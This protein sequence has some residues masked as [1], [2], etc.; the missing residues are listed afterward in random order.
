MNNETNL[1]DLLDE[2]LESP[3]LDEIERDGAVLKTAER[4]CTDFNYCVTLYL[5]KQKKYVIVYK[6]DNYNNRECIMFREYCPE[7]NAS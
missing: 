4:F 3:T 2:I 6:C 5:Y 7:D 1:L